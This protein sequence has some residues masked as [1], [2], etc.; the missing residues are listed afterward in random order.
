MPEREIFIEHVRLKDLYA[1]AMKI[2]DRAKPGEFVPISQQ[3]AFSM[4]KNPYA[5]PEDVALLVAY[6]G[7]ELIGYFGIMAV[8]LQT[9]REL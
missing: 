8:M 5:E 1:F 6:Q 3:R 7:D 2:I 4:T 9:G